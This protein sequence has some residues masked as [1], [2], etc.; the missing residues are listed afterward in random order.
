GLAGRLELA[1]RRAAV[2]RGEVAVVAL[3]A[4]VEDAVAADVG[5][6]A[7]DRAELVGLLPTGGEAR[8][9]DPNEVRTAGAAGDRLVRGRTADQPGQ[10]GAC[11][12]GQEWS[13]PTGGDRR[14]EGGS[15]PRG[16]DRDARAVLGEAHRPQAICLQHLHPVGVRDLYVP[17]GAAPRIL[18]RMRLNTTWSPGTAWTPFAKDPSRAAT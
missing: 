16:P 3:L 2:A 5:D 15:R 18:T 10:R 1:G 13:H 6:L 4:E 7:D 11:Q 8:T 12:C 17:P 9:L 14:R